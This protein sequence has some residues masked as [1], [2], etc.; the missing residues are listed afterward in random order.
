MNKTGVLAEAYRMRK[1]LIKVPSTPVTKDGIISAGKEFA[2]GVF[3][4]AVEVE[5]RG[6]SKEI[7]T[8][9]S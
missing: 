3:M 8:T 5:A 2:A 4:L 6:V 9:A 1:L 7:F